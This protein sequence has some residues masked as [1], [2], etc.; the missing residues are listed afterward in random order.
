MV[1]MLPEL[2]KT[3]LVVK[4]YASQR[5]NKIFPGTKIQMTSEGHKYLGGTVG[6]EESKD[7]YMDEKVMEWINQLEVLGKIASAEPQAVYCAFVGGFKDKVTYTI[8][9]VP[10]ICKHL[11]KVDQAVDTKFIPTLTDGH[12]CNEMERK[13]LSIPVKYGGMGIAIFCDI[14]ENE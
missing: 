2:T 11:K 10:D 5:T 8:G 13:L 3:W 1:A 7:P 4:P 14:A 6:T 12:F 9:T